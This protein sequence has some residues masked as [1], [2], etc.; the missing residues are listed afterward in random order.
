RQERGKDH[1]SAKLLI[2]WPEFISDARVR[3]G[4]ASWAKAIDV[5]DDMEVA[6]ELDT[7]AQCSA[8]S[9]A[10]EQARQL[11]EA[12]ILEVHDIA[13]SGR[14]ERRG[15]GDGILGPIEVDPSEVGALGGQGD[16]R[17]FRLKANLEF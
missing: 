1:A 17:F 9:A 5:A 10:T 15:L 7:C 12:E 2:R 3:N 14:L 4:H 13:G 6:V 16:G 11:H 8:R